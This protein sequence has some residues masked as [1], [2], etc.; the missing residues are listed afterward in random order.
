MVEIGDFLDVP[1]G[2]IPGSLQR[3]V[4]SDHVEDPAAL[5]DQSLFMIAVHARKI[6]GNSLADVVQPYDPVPFPVSPRVPLFQ[7]FAAFDLPSMAMTST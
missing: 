4:S 6:D 5:S 2:F 3:C 1:V 7:P